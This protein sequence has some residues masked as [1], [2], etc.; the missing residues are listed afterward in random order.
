MTDAVSASPS[1]RAE[2]SQTLSTAP[3]FPCYQ[4]KRHEKSHLAVTRTRTPSHR[5][6]FAV[7][8][9]A[10]SAIS[11]NSIPIT[12]KITRLVLPRSTGD[13]PAA[14]PARTGSAAGAPRP[15]RSN[16]DAPRVGPGSARHRTNKPMSTPHR[17]LSPTRPCGCFARPILFALRRRL[18]SAATPVSHCHRPLLT[19]VRASRR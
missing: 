19:S 3:S 11:G 6:L 7:E 1:Q 12:S 10:C 16:N 9:L 4:G 13:T 17:D 2:T 18:R 5:Q 8:S 15:S 14:L